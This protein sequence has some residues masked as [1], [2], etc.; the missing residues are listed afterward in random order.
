M[1]YYFD[2]SFVLTSILDE[3][4]MEIT[5]KIWQE[6]EIR[7]SSILLKFEMYTVL[8]R[9]YNQYSQ[10]LGKEWLEKKIKFYN[11]LM[12]EINLRII[13]EKIYDIINLNSNICKSRTLD[14]IHLATLIEFKES[15]QEN[16]IILC[17]YDDQMKK[18]AKQLKIKIM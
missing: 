4:T 2:S 13:D 9:T 1:I 6:A 5:K 18:T 16:N 11:E 3:K 7:I 8:Q 10:K 14:A 12:N 15:L 17:T